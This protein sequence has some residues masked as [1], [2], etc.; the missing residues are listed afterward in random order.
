MQQLF[1]SWERKGRG[2]EGEGLLL[3]SVKSEE[4]VLS[5]SLYLTI[6]SFSMVGAFHS[7]LTTIFFP[8]PKKSRIN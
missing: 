8:L 4:S 3:F 5:F 1:S 7:T 6:K 2:A